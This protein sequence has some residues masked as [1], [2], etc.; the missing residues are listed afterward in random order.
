[1]LFVF[2]MLCGCASPV[3]V[4]TKQSEMI[5]NPD[6]VIIGSEIEGAYLARAA[7]D[8]G[9]S[10]VILDPREKAG[11]QLLQGQMLYLDE[12]TDDANNTLLQGKVE[13]LFTDFKKGSIRKIEDFETY[14]D[15]LLSGIHI[16]SG[17]EI[18]SIE[19]DKGIPG[20]GTVTKLMYKNKA[21]EEKSVEAKYWVENTDF[22]Y[23]SSQLSEDRIPGI[24]TIFQ[25]D[26]K[27]YMA[28]SL[29]M[30][31]KGV[32]WDIFQKSVMGLDRA[33]REEQYGGDTH[34]T[35]TFT[36]GFGKVGGRYTSSR[37]DLF[38]RGLNI[39]NQK[40]GETLINALLIYDVVPSDPER[41]EEAVALGK[42]ET[43]RILP[44]L[45]KE[46]PGWEQA[47]INGYPDYLYIRDYD[48]YETD[49]V[50]SAR[51]MFSGKM[52]WDN[53]SIGGY[54]LDIQGIKTAPWGK[55]IGHP[56]KYGMPL[57]SFILKDYTNVLVAG[58]NVGASAAAYGSAR[59]QPNT[60]LAG[61]VIGIV[62]GQIDGK[63]ELV[64][65]TERDMGELHA[66]IKKK[67][68][69][70]L[71]GENAKNKLGAYTEEELDQIDK[72]QIHVKK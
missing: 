14:Y 66:Y 65:L 41:V 69:I 8:E 30:K 19:V 35:N 31:F 34:V 26:K 68:K 48:R 57:R 22:A 1:M 37:D 46:L 51:D 63:L 4:G 38:L 5:D 64:D 59:I 72:G 6:L 70:D 29:I 39:L 25:S 42:A 45:Q 2:L 9:L 54:P 32:D 49:Y 13:Q 40:D 47:Q 16:E 3:G 71:K 43:D 33:A 23:L 52:F 67:Y 7:K 24:E 10:V 12:P 44:H 17:I 18:V 15:N 27:E 28:S 60:S 56:D 11:G 62:L 50:L 21:G 53:V 61:E 55:G 58:K 20:K 36:W